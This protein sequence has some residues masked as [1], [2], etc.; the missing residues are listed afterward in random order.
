MPIPIESS[1]TAFKFT[2]EETIAARTLNPEQ[3]AYLQT[4]LC[5]AAEEKLAEEYDPQNRLRF[6][7][8]E[9]YIRGQM[10]ILNLLLNT[11][12]SQLTRP[13]RYEKVESNSTL[14]ATQ[15]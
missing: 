6:V 7:Q 15:S 8:R 5:D 14:S 13:K 10:D 9:A 12:V 4:L 3:R 11:D 2:A 1:F